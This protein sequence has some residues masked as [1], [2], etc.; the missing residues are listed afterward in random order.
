MQALVGAS[1]NFAVGPTLRCVAFTSRG[2]P[3]PR[4]PQ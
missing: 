2:P 4:H 1:E 3:G